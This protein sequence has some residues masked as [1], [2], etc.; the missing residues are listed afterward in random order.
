MTISHAQLV[1]ILAQIE[2][3]EGYALRLEPASW[4]PGDPKNTWQID[5]SRDVSGVTIGQRMILP[6]DITLE[7]AHRAIPLDLAAAVTRIEA[8]PNPG[9]PQ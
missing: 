1:R 7:T 2:L 8:A 6:P 9:N 3:P 5:V 4:E